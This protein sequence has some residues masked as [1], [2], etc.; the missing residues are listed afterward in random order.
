[1]HLFERKPKVYCEFARLTFKKELI[2]PLKPNDVFEIYVRND[3][4]TF[5]MSKNEFHNYFSN[6]VISKSYND[7]GNYNYMKTPSK[8]YKF[9]KK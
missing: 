1:M 2:D 5:I 3:D 8:A 7:I 9:L 6:V 4:E